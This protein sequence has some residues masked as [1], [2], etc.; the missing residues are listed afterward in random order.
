MSAAAHN[1][2][3]DYNPPLDYMHDALEQKHKG[4]PM[5]ALEPE[6]G[7]LNKEPELAVIAS[8]PLSSTR[9]DKAAIVTAPGGASSVP[10]RSRSDKVAELENLNQDPAPSSTLLAPGG[11]GE[12]GLGLG[13]GHGLDRGSST[14]QA[15]R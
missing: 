2:L 6:P 14:G 4:V 9:S 3:L 15:A 1:P 7:V 12:L 8:G 10:I 5:L 13:H 11:G